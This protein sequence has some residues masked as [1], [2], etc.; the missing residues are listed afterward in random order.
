MPGSLQGCM[1]VLALSLHK[2]HVYHF[3][4]GSTHQ[5]LDYRASR[6]SQV[7]KMG[8]EKERSFNGEIINTGLLF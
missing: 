5:Q 1:I 7:I 6:A 4:P 8:I 2:I 3:F